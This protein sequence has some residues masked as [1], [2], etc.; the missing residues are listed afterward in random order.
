MTA[1]IRLQALLPTIRRLDFSSHSGSGSQC[2]WSGEGRGSVAVAH[3]NDGSLTFTETGHFWPEARAARPVVFRN[4][5]RWTPGDEHVALAHERRGA[6]AAVRLFDLI[7][8]PPG[9]SADLVSR[10]AHLCI[11]DRY[12][13]RLTFIDD[14]FDLEWTIQGPKKDERLYYRYRR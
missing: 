5:F 2:A 1:I 10:R 13:A 4:V 11:D 14:G 7:G 12:R 9:E 3:G 8:A 6:D